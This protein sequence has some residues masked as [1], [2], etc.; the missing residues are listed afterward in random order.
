[1]NSHERGLRVLEE[2]LELAQAL[3][4]TEAEARRLAAHVFA[5]PADD[6]RKEFPQV[7]ICLLAAVGAYGL[8]LVQLV[9]EEW[10]RIIGLGPEH[11][12]ERMRRKIELGLSAESVP[13]DGKAS[14]IFAGY[15]ICPTCNGGGRAPVDVPNICA[16]CE[17]SGY[18]A[19]TP[20]GPVGLPLGSAGKESSE[21]EPSD[22]ELWLKAR[23]AASDLTAQ[24]RLLN[25][26][27]FTI[28]AYTAN[29]EVFG[30]HY[31]LSAIEL[32]SAKRTTTVEFT[33][34]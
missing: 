4:V 16:R 20:V 18:A 2:S 22:E 25:G 12:G 19:T 1:M 7:F 24:L 27:G 3:R 13:R 5:K 32:K 33:Y 8:D 31:S 28:T 29:S 21:A 6:P 30:S 34:E 17:G 11:F 9:N 26:R 10:D 15:Q 23:T 14:T